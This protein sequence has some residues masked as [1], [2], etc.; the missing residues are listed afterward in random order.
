MDVQTFFESM[1]VITRYLFVSIFASTS[2]VQFNLLN[3]QMLI[4][5]SHA[6][7]HDYQ[8]WRILSSFLFAGKF[9]MAFVMTL[10]FIYSFGAKLEKRINSSEFLWLLIFEMSLISIV[11]LLVIPMYMPLPALMFSLIY[12]FTKYEPESLFSLWGVTL[13]GNQFA[14]AL[15]AFNLLMGQDVIP[16]LVGLA[17][18]H[19]YFFL[20]EVVK[21]Q[22]GMDYLKCPEW[23][24][25][26]IE[27]IGGEVPR[28]RTAN[29]VPQQRG[30]LFQ[31]GGQKLG[32]K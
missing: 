12:V 5:E 7:I 15:V 21:D 23:I 31:G 22:Y 29:F 26:V 3:P 16:D 30:G 19:V 2:L 18:G 11:S 13:K 14:F 8:L 17:C 20:K 4:L 9:S 28:R 27:T 25:T 10:Y 1:P 32:N 6:I 24:N